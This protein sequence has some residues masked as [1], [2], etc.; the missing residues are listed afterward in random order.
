MLR[1][2]VVFGLLE[3]V[4]PG[5]MLARQNCPDRSGIGRFLSKKKLANKMASALFASFFLDNCEEI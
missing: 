4:T 1:V 5:V 3:R 2:L